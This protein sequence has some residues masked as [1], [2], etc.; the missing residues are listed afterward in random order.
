MDSDDHDS[1]FGSPPTLPKPQPNEDTVGAPRDEN[2]LVLPGTEFHLSVA[3]PETFAG[4]SPAQSQLTM[5]TSLSDSREV[6]A[7]TSGSDIFTP[8]NVYPLADQ[9]A[10]GELNQS[11]PSAYSSQTLEALRNTTGPVRL[12]PT[13]PTGGAPFAPATVPAVTSTSLLSP[14]HS[15]TSQ[16]EYSA[17]SSPVAASS[18]H[19]S[20]ASNNDA[21]ASNGAR[22]GFKK[23]TKCNKD[24][25]MPEYEYMSPMGNQLPRAQCAACREKRRAS[26]ARTKNKKDESAARA[27]FQGR[28]K[29]RQQQHQQQQ[30]SRGFDGPATQTSFS[31]PLIPT[32]TALLPSP[33]CNVD[34]VAQKSPS[35][36]TPFGQMPMSP[37]SSA[38]PRLQ[39]GF[40]HPPDLGGSRP[41]ATFGPSTPPLSMTPA[42]SG[43][44]FDSSTVDG[45]L[46]RDL[47]MFESDMA[48]FAN[49]PSSRLPSPSSALPPDLTT[50][51]SHS[52]EQ[53]QET[54]N[55]PLGTFVTVQI[56]P[57]TLDE[58]DINLFLSQEMERF[59]YGID[60]CTW[61][62]KQD[63]ATVKKC[64]RR[65][66]AAIVLG[67]VEVP[68]PN[69]QSKIGV[70]YSEGSHDLLPG[71][72]DDYE[73]NT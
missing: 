56:L 54:T 4:S 20:V 9:K 39:N 40:P 15:F 70:L 49:H 32:M 3:N 50:E 73:A 11:G 31:N 38:F 37:S 62:K 68:P 18:A 2:P 57:V 29:H 48:A 69:L 42:L 8:T 61:L 67:L 25:P 55:R 34:V 46:I 7:P 35:I 10:L 71:W 52:Q 59:R 60:K 6:P 43:L 63:E 22:Q 14:N 1:L 44:S 30:S 45:Q 66:E 36:P 21:T 41:T 27:R 72:H 53:Q 33:E 26:S 28:Q 23:C 24:K 13:L 58:A 17:A 12:I 19:D 16:T 5:P 51:M 64:W 47:E 65:R